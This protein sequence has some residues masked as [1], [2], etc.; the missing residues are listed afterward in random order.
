MTKR[1][2]LIESVIA[3]LRV[4]EVFVSADGGCLGVTEISKISG[5]KKERVFRILNTLTQEGYM[6]QDPNSKE[7]RLGPG[8]L[9]IG[10]AY[11]SK[12]DVRQHA[13][14]Y[15][16]ALAKDSGDTAYLFILAGREAL[17]IDVR[18]G[19]HVVQ[20]KSRV[21]QQIPLHFGAAP[22]CLLAY[23]P[24][25]R[26]AELLRDLPLKLYTEKTITDRRVLKA[27][28]Q[29]I[30]MQ[31]YYLAEDNYAVDAIFAIGAPIR[32][33]QG[34]AVAAISIA[35]PNSRGQPERKEELIDLVVNAA[36][37]LSGKLGFSNTGLEE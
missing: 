11:R 13:I 16:E 18:V 35:T 8:F 17:C 19:A 6:E 22:K 20:A 32:D 30:R 25:L 23:L 7:Y 21:G 26:Q 2:Y 5:L 31:G 15:L 37:E 12:L 34:K 3:A 24:Q 10:E 29:N 14:P 33:R 28:L 1:Q 27:E 36:R 4:A 9:V